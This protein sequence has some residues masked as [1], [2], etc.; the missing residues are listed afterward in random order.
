MG[1]TIH[2]LGMATVMIGDAVEQLALLG[3]ES[4]NCIVTSPPYWSLRDYGVDGQIGLEPTFAEFLDRL[5]AVFRECHRVLRND[6]TMWVNMGD[7][8]AGSGNSGGAWGGLQQTNRGSTGKANLRNIVTDGIPPKSLI[9]QPWRL[10]FALQDAGWIIRSDIIWSKPNPMPESVRDR[11]TKAHEYIFLLT[12]SATYWYDADAIK[13]EAK[14]DKQRG[15]SRSHAG[16]NDRWDLMT[17]EEQTANGANARTVW[18]IATKPYSEAHFATFPPEIPRRCIK[19]G[20][21]AGG[22]VLDPFV[23]SG[24]T[25]QVATELGCNSIGIDLNEKNVGLIEKRLSS[26]TPPLFTE[27]V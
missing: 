10:A 12:K 21:P 22:V 7:S 11:P 9:G 27:A 3:D 26:V 25:L 23:G 14:S 18:E 4:V 5:L 24:T 16:F 1:R 19:A 13:T 20:C 15:H 17:K 2:R 8:Y 6:G